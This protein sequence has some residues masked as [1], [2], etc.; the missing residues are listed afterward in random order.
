M[1]EVYGKM[2]QL[3][4]QVKELRALVSQTTSDAAKGGLKLSPNDGNG[5]NSSP[6][7]PDEDDDY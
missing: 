7:H 2:A 6:R 5:Y 3:E 4:G 1:R